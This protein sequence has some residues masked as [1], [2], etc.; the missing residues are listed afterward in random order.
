LG[1]SGAFIGQHVVVTGGGR[2]IG[3]ACAAAFAAAGAT[4]TVT[5]RDAAAL[6]EA[7]SAGDAHGSSAF[8]IRDEVAT[9]AAF[10]GIVA[11]HGPV[12]ILVANAGAA[13]SA[14]FLKSDAALFRRMLDLNLMGVVNAVH[15]VLPA[16]LE[17]RSGRVI[18]VSSTAGLKGYAYVT[19]YTA[20]KHAVIGLVRALALETAATGVTVNAVCPGYTE[21]GLVR[22]T[23]ANIAAKTGRS[24]EQA[25]QEILRDKPLRRLIQPGEVA[26]ACLYLASAGAAAVTGAALPVAGAEL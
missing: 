9:R 22:Q 11:S 4:V 10:G 13:E 7:V 24:E 2:G 16:M 8:D 23:I 18:A 21:T 17:R 19:A 26:A 3:R 1:P 6:A 12:T 5:G 25:L 14:P 15:C 20:A